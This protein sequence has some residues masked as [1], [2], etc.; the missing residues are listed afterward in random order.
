MPVIVIDTDVLIALLQALG[1]NVTR[2]QHERA[3]WLFEQLSESDDLVITAP[4]L[5]EF[6]VGIPESDEKT[7][8]EEILERLQVYT[9]DTASAIEAGRLM[10][11]RVECDGSLSDNGHRQCVKTDALILGTAMVN[12][13][14]KVISFD[15]RLAALA[16]KGLAVE[17]PPTSGPPKQGSLFQESDDGP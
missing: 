4:T 14:S 12:K 1:G 6:M 5:A 13:A 7:A 17:E 3:L 10:R 8:L 2:E 9:L 15:S 16:D 11:N